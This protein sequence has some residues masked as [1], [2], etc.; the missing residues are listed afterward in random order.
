MKCFFFPKN[1]I[2]LFR[3]TDR[4]SIQQSDKSSEDKLS[5]HIF[6]TYVMTLKGDIRV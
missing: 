3:A 4:P 2:Y 1:N 6:S 5:M